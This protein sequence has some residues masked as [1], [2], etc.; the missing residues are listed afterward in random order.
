MHALLVSSATTQ[1]LQ[2]EVTI[3]QFTK[4]VEVMDFSAF[5]AELC[6]LNLPEGTQQQREEGR[7]SV[8]PA[9]QA[10]EPCTWPATTLLL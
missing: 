5:V 1:L 9:H 3:Q 7:A 4:L 2:D 10:V 8:R 6:N